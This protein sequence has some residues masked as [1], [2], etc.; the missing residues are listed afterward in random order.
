MLAACAVVP[1]D[2][3]A[4]LA[5]AGTQD[6]PETTEVIIGENGRPTADDPGTPQLELSGSS[7]I[8]GT[9][10]ALADNSVACLAVPHTNGWVVKVDGQEVDTYRANYGFIGFTVSEGEHT[11]EAYYEAPNA[12]VGAAIAACGLVG[13]IAACAFTSRRRA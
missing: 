7:R 8:S 5:S 2:V 3:A 4:E 13:G 6:V 1:D 10:K 12:K 9:F 11:I